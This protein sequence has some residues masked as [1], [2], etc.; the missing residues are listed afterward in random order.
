MHPL[1][2]EIVE[3]R[4]V[5]ETKTVPHFRDVHTGMPQHHPCLC[6][7][8][9][10]NML[11]GRFA[12]LGFYGPV[13]VVDMN[14]QLVGKILGGA[15][16]KALTRQ[17][18]R[19]LAVE[20]FEKDSRNP[21]GSIRIRGPVRQRRQLHGEIDDLDD[22]GLDQ[23]MLISV[24]AVQFDLHFSEKPAHLFTL[25]GVQGEDRFD[26]RQK[27]RHFVQVDPQIFLEKIFFK[28]AKISAGIRRQR[29]IGIGHPGIE[30]QQAIAADGYRFIT[31]MK[32][33]ITPEQHDLVKIPPDISGVKY[34]HPQALGDVGH[35]KMV[36][37]AG[38]LWTAKTAAVEFLQG[39]RCKWHSGDF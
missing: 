7:Q 21:R 13:E 10:E 36:L 4:L 6:R 37:R 25:P 34:P 16:Q 32:P 14:S 39:L 23:L 17:L 5:L 30:E 28:D 29:R 1:P 9:F 20:Q 15:Q 8:P 31:E 26:A 2:E 22:I 3:M 11:A 38:L 33:G 18:Y 19:K 24:V 27:Q 12:G 35:I